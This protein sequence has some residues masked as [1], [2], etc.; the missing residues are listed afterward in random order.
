MHDISPVYARVLVRELVK[1]GYPEAPLF[2]GTSLNR[3]QL[4][5]G[6]NI[7]ANDFALILENARQ[8]SGNP[9][10]GL[11]IG[12]HCNV[13]TLGPVGAAM[14]TAPTLREGLQIL[15][16]FTRL[17]SSYADIKLTSNLAGVSVTTSFLGL[18]GEVERFH[19]E[20]GYLM[21]QH[22]IEMISGEPL[23]NV[24]FRFAYNK[25]V[26]AHAYADVLHGDLVFNCAAHSVDLPRAQLDVASPFFN[27]EIWHQAQLLLA[28][29][30]SEL[31]DLLEKNYSQHV[32]ALLRSL[33]PPL[34]ELATV[35]RHLHLSDRTLNRRLKEEGTT[36][37]N[38]RSSE[39][40][41][42]ARRYLTQTDLS[43]EAIGAVLG[44]QDAANFRRAFRVWES[45]SPSEF[46]RQET[47]D[48]R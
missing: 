7:S 5:S 33:E 26:Y 22:I 44:Y 25:P 42:W 41:A 13:I 27:A 35:A 30:L 14:A 29:R 32:A 43:V 40:N 17:H 48:A 39:M 10:L 9:R 34:P 1:Q 18:R 45:C 38:I 36:F 23:D 12:R 31:T 46:R 16:H 28:Q 11:L 20:S 21:L 8:S 15:E 24:V 47:S 19:V 4:D 3:Q 6:G 2:V 37:R